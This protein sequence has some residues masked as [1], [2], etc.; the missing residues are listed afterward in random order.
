MTPLA[1]Q[2]CAFDVESQ[3]FE[4]RYLEYLETACFASS[5]LSDSDNGISCV[6]SI[7][8]TQYCLPFSVGVLCCSSWATI[9]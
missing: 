9:D 4:A 3:L 7:C 6:E 1:C 2:L 5:Y 8:N